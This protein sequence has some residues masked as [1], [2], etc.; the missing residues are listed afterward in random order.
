MSLLNFFKPVN[1]LPSAEQMDLPEQ[2]IS[3]ANRAVQ[4]MLEKERHQLED[5]SGNRGRKR[6]YTMTFTAEDCAK[7]GKYTAHNGVAAACKNFKQSNIGE[8]T[9]RHFTKKYLDEVSK[10]AKAGDST[11]VST[12]EVTKRGRK[13]LLHIVSFIS[14]LLHIVSLFIHHSTIFKPQ[15]FLKV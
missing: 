12:L 3:S 5:P 8:S 6:K 9:V 11:D 7:I 2:A 13:L 15:L 1:R 10:H 4:W 14:L